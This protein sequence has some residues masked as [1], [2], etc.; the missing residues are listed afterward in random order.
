M[1]WIVS[2]V[3]MCFLI[4]T[5]IDDFYEISGFNSFGIVDFYCCCFHGFVGFVMSDGVK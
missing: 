5:I 1:V 3:W 2:K 4:L